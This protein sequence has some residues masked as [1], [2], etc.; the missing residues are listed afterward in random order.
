LNDVSIQHAVWLYWV[1]VHAGVWGNEIADD[2]A[3]GSSILGFLGPELALGV[4]IQY[5]KKDKLLVGQPA[6]GEMAKSW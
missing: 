2:L 4:S 1:P 5:T 6:L 3:R